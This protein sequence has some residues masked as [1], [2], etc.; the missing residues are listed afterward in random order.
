MIIKYAFRSQTRRFRRTILS[1]VGVGVGCAM[2]IIATCWIGGEQEMTVRAASES[3]AGHL[4]IVPAGWLETRENTLR[5]SEWKRTLAL[6]RSLPGVKRVAF[7]ARTDGLLAFGNRTSGVEVTGVDPDSERAFNRI[8]YKSKI[9]G[10]YL[11]PGDAGQAVIGRELARRLKVGLD[12]DLMITL[13]GKG[14]IESAM[15]RIVGILDTG[16][17]ELDLSV[18]HIT[19]TEL[20][21]MTGISGP[22]EISIL[23]DNY[24]RID[25]TREVLARELSG[26][27]RVI[28]WKEVAPE[29]AAGME[30]DMA[31][32]RLLV[33]IIIAVVGLGIMS[34]QLT[35]VMERRREFGILSALGMPGRRIVGMI[36]TEAF[37]IGLGG[38]LVA[39]AVSFP[40]TYRLA[41]RGVNLSALMGGLNSFGG[42]LIDP[43]A[44]GDLGWWV[45]WYA[46]GV[47]LAATVLASLYPAR[48]AQKI[49]PA[50]ALRRI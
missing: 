39:L 13:S 3:G 50:E 49:D 38:A 19:L 5:I 18:C 37:L 10:R 32:A 31:F 22:A 20:E 24:K 7:R 43:V 8:V 41:S 44:Y 15:L 27:N 16:S 29:L 28:T 25:S 6:A 26:R 4:K 33:L 14:E 23:L 11:E 46:F 2:G 47:S 17:Q 45:V 34:A 42:V 30:G 9:Q 36:L 40:I 12:D 1:V 48:L 21:R 35:A